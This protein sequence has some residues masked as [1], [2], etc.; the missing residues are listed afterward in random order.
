MTAPL[1][2]AFIPLALAPDPGARRE[3]F[4]ILVA[5]HPEKARSLREVNPA[6][7]NPSTPRPNSSK[8]EPKVSLHREAE[9]ITGIHIECSCG[10]IIDLKCNY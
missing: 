8:C 5:E 9:R 1:N 4:R 3:D 10:Q 6:V 2:N 7:A